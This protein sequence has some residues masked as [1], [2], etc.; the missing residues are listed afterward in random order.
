M[1]VSPNAS[2]F[3][4]ALPGLSVLIRDLDVVDGPHVSH[5]HLPTPGQLHPGHNQISRV[6]PNAGPAGTVAV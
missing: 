2:Y 3:K 1:I 6:V 4:A 5:R